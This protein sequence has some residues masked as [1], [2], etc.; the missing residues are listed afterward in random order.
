M[1]GEE[2]RRKLRVSWVPLVLPG[3]LGRG[4]GGNA[5]ESSLAV[6]TL[7]W[8]WARPS[9]CLETEVELVWE[10]LKQELPKQRAE[11]DSSSPGSLLWSKYQPK[12]QFGT[13]L[14]ELSSSG[15][16]ESQAKLKGIWCFLKWLILVLPRCLS[17]CQS[18]GSSTT[19]SPPACL[20]CAWS[21]GSLDVAGHGLATPP[22]LRGGQWPLGVHIKHKRL[23]QPQCQSA[24]LAGNKHVL[25][26]TKHFQTGVSCWNFLAAP[27]AV[28]IMET[29]TAFFL[30]NGCAKHIQW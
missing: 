9:W 3:L 6:W 28:V 29:L 22:T 23:V 17:S 4:S 30:F 21:W 25:I 13:E 11:A 27:K 20:C 2:E 7:S 14:Q 1:D 19:S 18:Q 16:R 12:W 15:P 24:S 5:A 8:P 26:K 10:E